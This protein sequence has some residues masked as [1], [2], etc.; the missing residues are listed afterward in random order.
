[1]MDIQFTSERQRQ[2]AYDHLAALAKLSYDLDTEKHLKRW[3][4]VADLA[5]KLL[6]DEA[7]LPM[8]T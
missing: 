4:A 6:G 2:E 5:K 8:L 1:M 7:D 3:K